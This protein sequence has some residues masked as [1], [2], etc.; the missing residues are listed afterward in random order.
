MH[1]YDD[2]PHIG[3]DINGKRILRPAKGDELDKFLA[4]TEDP[5][6]WYASRPPRKSSGLLNIPVF[7]G[8]LA[9]TTPLR[10]TPN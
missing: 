8:C 2:L 1:W 10:K 5:T 6:S 4:A 3:Y 9:S 7:L